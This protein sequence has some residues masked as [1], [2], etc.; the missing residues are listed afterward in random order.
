MSL[1]TRVALLSL[2]VLACAPLWL[3]FTPLLWLWLRRQRA[4][5]RAT[6]LRELLPCHAA[7]LVAYAEATLLEPPAEGWTCVASNVDRY[8]AAV[9]SPRHW[10]TAMMLTVLEFA[11]CLLLRRRLS[12]Q[13]LPAR[14]RWIE[15]HY[16]TTRGLFALPSLARQLARMGYYT[17]PSVAQSLGF[18][19]MRQRA[20]RPERAQTSRVAG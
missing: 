7:A 18:R 19:T 5:A 14:Q 3:P 6:G 16:S 9:R 17:A 8:L 15:R 4:H 10:R 12:R 11:P 13:P 2:L 20:R 1:N